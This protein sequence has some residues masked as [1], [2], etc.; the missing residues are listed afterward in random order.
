MYSLVCNGIPLIPSQT[1]MQLGFCDRDI[2]YAAQETLI[3]S[4]AG[5]C[6]DHQQVSRTVSGAC[7]N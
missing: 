1:N 6:Y 3:P 5:L 2:A 7:G 4:H